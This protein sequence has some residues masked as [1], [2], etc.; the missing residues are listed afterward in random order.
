MALGSTA[1]LYYDREDFFLIDSTTRKTT[2]HHSA[3]VHRQYF[4]SVVSPLYDG[5]HTHL[6]DTFFFCGHVVSS[7]TPFGEQSISNT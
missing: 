2:K 3:M 4:I 5:V 7:C 6:H 1:V